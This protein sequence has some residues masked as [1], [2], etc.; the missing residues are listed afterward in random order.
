MKL[1]LT[2]LAALFVAA[3]TLSAQKLKHEGDLSFVQGQDKINVEFT[4]DNLT[5]GKKDRKSEQ[6]YIDESMAEREKAEMGAGEKWLEGWQ[7]AR[8]N[9][10]HPAFLEL[11]NKVVTKKEGTEFGDFPDAQYTLVFDV[12]MMEPGWNIGIMKQPA[13]M[14]GIAYFYETGNREAP[15]A[16]VSITGAPGSQYGGYDFDVASRLKESFAIS[17]KRLG[18][19]L[20]KK[21]Y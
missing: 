4:Y 2:L 5:V 12:L 21:G 17:G 7:T 3:G 13:E 15:I 10:Y 9:Y 11:I 18:A 20:R 1:K 14:D 8:E 6:E 16:E 19:Y